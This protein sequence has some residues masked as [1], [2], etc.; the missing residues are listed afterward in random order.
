MVLV[1]AGH[2]VKDGQCPVPRVVGGAQIAGG[3]LR[4]SEM[5][6]N[7]GLVDQVPGPAEEPL[8]LLITLHRPRVIAEAAM[9]GPQGV[10]AVRR[11]IVVTKV[12]EDGERFLAAGQRRLVLT[13]ADLVPAGVAER[14]GQ[15]GSVADAAA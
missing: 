15:A 9:R 4:L 3:A 10:Q 1:V 8:R 5:G 11:T 2:R 13:K 7:S 6:E 14:A 12:T